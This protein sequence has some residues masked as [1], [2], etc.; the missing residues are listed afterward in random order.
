MPPFD[1][2]L[3]HNELSEVVASLQEEH[4]ELV[5]RSSIGASFEGRDI[6]LLTIT[7]RA[8][9][10]ASEKPALWVDAN[11]HATELT[12][13]VAALHL[14]HRLVTGH[15]SDPEVTRALDTRAFYIVPRLNPDGAELALLERPVEL[16]SSTRPYPRVAQQDG[17]HATPRSA[18]YSATNR[19]RASR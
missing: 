18:G 17:L 12:G 5:E 4:P 14:A 9:G 11:I 8:T 15:G 19:S 6:W 13:S 16:R 7:N 3:R 1:R 10:P 2:F